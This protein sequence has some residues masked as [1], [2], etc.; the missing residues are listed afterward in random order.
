MAVHGYNTKFKFAANYD[1]NQ[2]SL[3]VFPS[4]LSM[5]IGRLESKLFELNFKMESMGVADG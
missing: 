4:I 2:S 3:D 5:V 1:A